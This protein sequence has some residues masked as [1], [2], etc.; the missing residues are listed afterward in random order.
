LLAA[1]RFC[2][3]H[4][5]GCFRINSQI[6]P[7]K[8]HPTAGY[9]LSELPAADAIIAAF[10]SCRTYVEEHN[11]RVVFHP[12]QF[13]VLNSPHEDVVQKSFTNSNITPRWPN[14]SAL[15]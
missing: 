6:L 11:L 14:G 8:T 2:A 15:M 7:V 13:V 3:E 4:G 1:L 5:I 12:D 9:S 10:L